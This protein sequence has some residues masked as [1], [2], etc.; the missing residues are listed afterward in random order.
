M[1][2]AVYRYQPWD[3]LTLRCRLA[4]TESGDQNDARLTTAKA[5]TRCASR[6]SY[7]GLVFFV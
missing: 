4:E 2:K 7:G 3:V 6:D 5:P 1:E